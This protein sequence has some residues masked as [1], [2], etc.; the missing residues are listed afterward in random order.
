MRTGC[1]NL[2]ALGKRLDTVFVQLMGQYEE[3][4]WGVP[5]RVGG[6]E[7]P[8]I[9]AAIYAI[10]GIYGMQENQVT[11]STSRSNVLQVVIA[12]SCNAAL[13]LVLAK[14]LKVQNPA[15]CGRTLLHC[16]KCP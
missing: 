6:R 15:R 1:E 11:I 2:D 5:G 8:L 13:R 14:A 4:R 9:C 16:R 10:Y 12:H 7:W 3:A